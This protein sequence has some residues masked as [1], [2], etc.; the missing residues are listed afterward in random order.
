MSEEGVERVA[1]VP[2]L[3]NLQALPEIQKPGTPGYNEIK[4]LIEGLSNPLGTII[5]EENGELVVQPEK[6]Q[7]VDTRRLLL[8]RR[9]SYPSLRELATEPV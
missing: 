8:H 6:R 7:V 3:F 9:I 5:V 4:A 2:T 1:F